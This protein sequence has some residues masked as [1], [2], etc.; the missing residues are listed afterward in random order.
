[1]VTLPTA[2]PSAGPVDAG[3]LASRAGQCG[4]K[5]EGY[6]CSIAQVTVSAKRVEHGGRVPNNSG[7]SLVPLPY[8]NRRRIPSKPSARLRRTYQSGLS[9]SEAARFPDIRLQDLPGVD[10]ST[11]APGR[12]PAPEADERLPAHPRSGGAV[13]P[14]RWA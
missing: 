6:Y 10:H 12:Q 5:A 9:T 8:L 13:M 2:S 7:R 14:C 1:M 4:Q 11:S 3:P